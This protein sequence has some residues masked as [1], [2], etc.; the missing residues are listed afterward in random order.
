MLYKLLG[1]AVWK[2]ARWYVGKRVSSLVPS[3]RVA[4]GAIVVGVVGVAALLAARSD[5]EDD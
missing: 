2:G 5:R 1:Y 3:R 4:T